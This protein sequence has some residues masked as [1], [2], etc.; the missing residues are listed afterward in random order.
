MVAPS[1]GAEKKIE[2]VYATRNL[3]CSTSKP[4]M[5]SNGLHDDTIST[6]STVDKRDGATNKQTN[7]QTK[8]HQTFCARWRACEVAAHNTRRGDKG[9]PYQFCTSLT[10]RIRRI[11]SPVKR[12]K[13]F[14]GKS[15]Y[16]SGN[17]WANLAKFKMLIGHRTANKLNILYESHTSDTH[18]RGVYITKFRKIYNFSAPIPHPIYPTPHFTPISAV[19]HVLDVSTTMAPQSVQHVAPAC[20]KRHQMDLWVV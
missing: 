6:V 2:C 10:F 4:F 1:S 17:T 8:L 11:I 3:L 14:G 15:T 13:N 20:Q 7:K 5:N 16:N 18:L 19:V 9:G 12:A